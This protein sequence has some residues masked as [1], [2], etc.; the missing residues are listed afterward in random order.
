MKKALLFLLAG[1]IAYSAFAQEIPRERISTKAPTQ[2]LLPEPPGNG[3]AI[4]KEK[5]NQDPNLTKSSGSAVEF[6]QIGSAGN[7]YGFYGGPRT[8]LWADPWLNSVVFTHRMV[9]GAPEAEGNSRV[10]YDVSIDG[11]ANWATNVQVY[12]PLADGN[13]YPDAAGRYPQGA[14]INPMGNT[15]PA[16]ADYAYFIT[17]IIDE[18][19]IW[20]GVAYGNN[21][22]TMTDPPM[23]TQTNL[24]TEGGTKL[25]IIPDAFTVTPQGVA[26]QAHESSEYD[27]T[28]T[29][30]QGEY[31]VGRGEIDDNDSLVFVE[32][33]I[34]VLDVG[35]G[36]NFTKIAFS[37]DGQTGY[38]CI[39]SDSESDPQ[40]FTNYHPI[41][42][43]TED[44]GETWSDPIHILFGGEDG[45]E[46]LKNYFSDEAIIA[47]GYPE[48]FDRDE[49][50]YNMG[51]QVDMTVGQNGGVYIT[52]LI[53][54]GDAE[55][56]YPYSTQMATWNLYSL[57]G[58]ETWDADPLYDNLWFDG[59]L[60]AIAQWNRPYV[61]RT[62]DGHYLFFSWNDTDKE[63][64][65]E[66][67]E[68]NIF[69]VGYDVQDKTYSEV[70][71]VTYFTLGWNQA[72]MGSQSYYV[73]AEE[74]G[75]MW[76]CEIPLVYQQFTVPGDDASQCDYWYIDNFTMSMPVS[77]FEIAEQKTQFT[78]QQNFPNP[79]VNS[80]QILVNADTEESIELTVSNLLG[81][82]VYQETKKSRAL[83]HAFNLD[84]SDLMPGVY[85]YTV[86][87]GAE[88]VTKRMV[89]E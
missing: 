16:N 39:M 78:V 9:G 59:T 66:N 83:V 3:E 27:G 1:V 69:V 26:W 28:N 36:I 70:V 80:T 37:D 86:R 73:F 32:E 15:D 23:P 35:D 25:R 77:T 10:S 68:P 48:G 52:G 61:S 49:V 47:A 30:F 56:W 60:G 87:V 43:K 84:V 53:T 88:A 45:I 54:I 71:N 81:Q 58:G 14:I 22:L 40:E 74:N 65:V 42:L 11:G 57:D 76:D 8:Y 64:A 7:S 75:D 29:T 55:G 20:G 4:V 21:P 31:I 63:G 51:F 12:T 24:D 50:Y 62:A 34:D 5:P 6:I 82:Q 85:L 41:I 18:N 44:G 89:V 72:F 46:S 17:T 2:E 19:N 38:I 33:M 79:A 67:N 13:P